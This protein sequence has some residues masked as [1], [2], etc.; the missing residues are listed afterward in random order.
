MKTGALEV[1][2]S[3]GAE[4]CVTVPTSGGLRP[5]DPPPCFR[6]IRH[7]HMHLPSVK[8]TWRQLDELKFSSS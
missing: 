2:L 5:S 4:I 8:V 6:N 3:R 7:G 1:L